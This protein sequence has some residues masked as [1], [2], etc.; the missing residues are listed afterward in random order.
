MSLKSSLKRVPLLVPTWQR[1]QRVKWVK[2]LADDVRLWQRHG[3]FA[4]ERLQMPNSGSWLYVNP[5]E[6]RG[7]AVLLCGA[8]GQRPLRRHIAADDRVG[9][10]P[11]LRRISIR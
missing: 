1:L 7:R 4:P 3:R 11:E 8:E 10:W 6:N 2:Q 9:R 5:R